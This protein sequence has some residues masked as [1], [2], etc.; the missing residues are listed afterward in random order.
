MAKYGSPSLVIEADNAA[1][2][3]V[4]MTQ[5]VDEVNEVNV[6]ALIQESHTFGDS[7]VENLY[8]GVKKGNP[9]TFSGFYDDTAVSGPD[10][11]FNALGST[12]EVKITYGGSKYSHFNAIITSYVRTP[13][14]GELTRYSV[15]YTPTG[16]IFEDAA[17]S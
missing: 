15:T 2:T 1:G 6:E 10:V 12:R 13:T 4:D 16:Q 5:Y 3:L 9:V 11:I 17:P 8:T 14:R 7:W